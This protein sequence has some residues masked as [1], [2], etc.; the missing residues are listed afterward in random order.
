MKDVAAELRAR[1]EK[2]RVRGSRIA[3]RTG[4]A[5]YQEGK[6]DALDEAASLVESSQEARVEFSRSEIATLAMAADEFRD[7][8]IPDLR[9][10]LNAALRTIGG[11]KFALEPASTEPAPAIGSRACRCIPEHGH[12][13][14]CPV[15]P[16]FEP[17]PAVRE[18]G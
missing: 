17:A 13:E 9:D 6:A 2:A 11:D 18:E 3:A 16:S 14:D 10:R 15:N 4:R 8:G 7:T 5:D 1:A 12:L